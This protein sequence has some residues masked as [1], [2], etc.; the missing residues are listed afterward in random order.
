MAA[1]CDAVANTR[2]SAGVLSRLV[3][4]FETPGQGEPPIPPLVVSKPGLFGV[5]YL[6]GSGYRTEINGNRQSETRTS[7]RTPALLERKDSHSG[8][9]SVVEGIAKQHASFRFLAI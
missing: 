4:L 2:L 8:E 7:T 3:G 6:E 1:V 5:H 9:S